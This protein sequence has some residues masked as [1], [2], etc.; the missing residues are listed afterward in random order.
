MQINVEAAKE[1]WPETCHGR[2]MSEE[3]E[4]RLVSV[5]IPTYNRAHFLVEAMDSVWNQTYR[6]IELIVVDDGSTDN[7]P[8]VL[9]Q[10]AR[11]HS[12]DARFELRTFRQDNKGAPVARNLGAI[13][14]RGEYLQ[15]WDTEDLMLSSKLSRQVGAARN[16]DAD[17]VVSDIQFFRRTPGDL[18]RAFLWGS[19]SQLLGSTTDVVTRAI[20]KWGWNTLAVFFSRA[21]VVKAGPWREDLRRSQD[22]EFN[23]RAALRARRLVGVGEVLNYEREHDDPSCISAD[24]SPDA[25]SSMVTVVVAIERN[26]AAAGHMNGERGSLLS[27]RLTYLSSLCMEHG[28]RAQAEWACREAIRLAGPFRRVL[29]RL[30][31]LFMRHAGTDRTLWLDRAGRGLKASLRKVLRGGSDAP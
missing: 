31:L 12:G 19:Q 18:K 2:W 24:Y 29:L 20:S 5:I 11:A 30:Y 8:Q 22:V 10:W 23:C 16:H 26:L 3:Y 28:Y 7:T 17:I 21:T 1:L 14:S 4:P 6:P 13:Q 15:F 25:L 9:A 27:K